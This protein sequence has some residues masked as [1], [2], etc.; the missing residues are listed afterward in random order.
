MK[1]VESGTA[2]PGAF[3]Q[4]LLDF[5][6]PVL[7][8]LQALRAEIKQLSSSKNVAPIGNFLSVQQIHELTGKCPETIRKWCRSGRLRHTKPDREY[9]VK[10]EDLE[11]FLEGQ[12]AQAPSDVSE[13]EQ[14]RRVLAEVG[15]K[16]VRHG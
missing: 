2:V 9:F 11:A 15:S 12:K 14:V 4:F 8:E 3:E 7:E 16:K 5:Q 13:V 10:P 6:R 1:M